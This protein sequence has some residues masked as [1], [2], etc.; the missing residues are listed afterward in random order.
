MHVMV[1]GSVFVRLSS[2]LSRVNPE[3]W[4]RGVGLFAADQDMRSTLV[5]LQ[6]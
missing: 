4:E 3:I 5:G 1:S 2:D 6:L